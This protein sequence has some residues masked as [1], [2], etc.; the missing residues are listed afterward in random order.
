[1]EIYQLQYFIKTAEVLHFTKAAELCFVTQSGLS[2]QIKKL[3]EEL[4]MPLF[5]RIGKK[6]QLTEAGSVFLI[7]AKQVIE[8]VQSGKQA[9]DDL[10][11]MIGGELRIGVTYIFGLLVLPIVNLFAKRYPN[12]KIV[13]EYGS[14]EPL[15]QKLLNNELD[16][17]L[18]ISS[19][20][21]KETIQKIPLFTSNLVVAVAKT[22]PLA[23]LDKISFKKMEEFPLILPVRG[24]SS[25]EFLDELFLKN[26]MKPKVSIELNA[27][28]AL[29]QLVEESDWV[30][31]VTEKALKGWDN[32]KAIAI[33]GVPTQRDSF[34]LTIEG[35]YQKKAVK[36][37][38]EEFRKSM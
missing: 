10:N 27:V 33:T 22:H 19:K 2:Q 12:L 36:L 21:I 29:L 9:I 35:A 13:V 23:V 3:E 7:H 24:F 20:E 28:H 14:T 17:V 4:G 34:I 15:E 6:V 32:L 5:I 37:F 8:N 1:M 31:I 26:N 30:T 11:E 16:L 38:I 18:V 25:R